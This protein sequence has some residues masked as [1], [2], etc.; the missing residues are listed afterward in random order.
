[1]KA[2]ITSFIALAVIG[3]SVG[4]PTPVPTSTS[5][6]TTAQPAASSSQGA[7]QPPETTAATAAASAT[8]AATPTVTEV[9]TEAPSPTAVATSEA[10]S[11]PAPIVALVELIAGGGDQQPAN[12][13][14]AT[15]VLLQRTSSAAVA[16]D[17]TIWITDVNL[18]LL[19]HIAADGTLAD[20]VTGLTGPEGVSV[21]SDG[22]V[23][24]ADRGGYRVVSTT[25]DGLE[26]VAGQ[27]FNAGFRG[28]GGPARRSLLFQP[29]DV[30]AAL[31]GDVYIADTA[32]HRIRLIDAESGEIDTI[33]GNGEPGFSGDGGP[34]TDAQ[35][36]GPQAIALDESNGILAIADTTNL[37]LRL[38]DLATGI[39]TTAAGTGTGAVS[40]DP[41]LTGPQTPIT[42]I[43]ALAAD[44]AGNLYFTVFWGDVG[45]VVMRMAPD[46]TMTRVIGGG[47]TAAPSAS[48]SDFALPDVL[49]L[50]IDAASGALLIC[51]SD[52]KVWRVP[53]VGQPAIQ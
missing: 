6:A 34:A 27:E 48:A 37:R 19:M 21:A 4:G 43:A 14:L 20:I 30:I 25:G 10:T 3:C 31:N 53:N 32:N 1:V 36:Y 2:V 16:P 15:D 5:A 47:A 8:L 18:S 46:G 49:G 23:Y 24:I 52:G 42:R 40:Y 35:I 17:G 12:G 50:S 11:S 51:G 38:V 9:P 7:T 39:I 41:N 28:D 29:F 44:A 26:R 22:T 13:V 45:H 33:V